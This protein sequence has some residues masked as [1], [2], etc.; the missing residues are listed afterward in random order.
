[1]NF[2]DYCIATK[3]YS[4]LGAINDYMKITTRTFDNKGGK[5]GGS[6]KG[7]TA[8]KIAAGVL[9]AGALGA[10]AY[11]GYPELKKILDKKALEDVLPKNA[12]SGS[13]ADIARAVGESK[14]VA[15]RAAQHAQDAPQN[16]NSDEV[17]EMTHGSKGDLTGGKEYD[18]S[19]EDQNEESCKNYSRRFS[20]IYKRYGQYFR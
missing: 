6:S 10:G 16:V 14:A 4:T 11:Y 1:M 9:G 3:N 18:L 17:S 15:G 7:K 13:A 2:I 20:N 8:A 19:V 5:K 12:N